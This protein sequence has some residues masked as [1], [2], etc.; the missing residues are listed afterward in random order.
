MVIYRIE[1]LNPGSL[2]EFFVSELIWEIIEIEA[3]HLLLSVVTWW[4]KGVWSS[5]LDF[6][7][8]WRPVRVVGCMWAEMIRTRWC[9]WVHMLNILKVWS[10][11]F[12]IF[13]MGI[14]IDTY[15]EDKVTGKSHCYHILSFLIRDHDMLKELHCILLM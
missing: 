9:M 12:W 8:V 11:H 15:H 13:C 7:Y 1:D 14:P 4:Y 3:H 2:L 6:H 5:H 10:I